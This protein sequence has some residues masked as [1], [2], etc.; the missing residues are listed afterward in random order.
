MRKA[1]ETVRDGPIVRRREW[2]RVFRSAVFSVLVF[3]AVFSAFT[4]VL[5][6][7]SGIGTTAEFV[8]IE[9]PLL[10][11]G[12]V[13]AYCVLRD[14]RAR[15]YIAAL[16]FTVIYVA[17]DLYYWW[18]GNIFR[19][20]DVAELPELVEVLTIGEIAFYSTLLVAPLLAFVASLHPSRS[21]V[22]AMVAALVWAL[23]IAEHQFMPAVVAFV[24]RF[25]SVTEWS[26]QRSARDTG[27][28]ALMIYHEAQ[29]TTATRRLASFHGD[30]QYSALIEGRRTSLGSKGSRRNVHFIVLE[31]FLDPTLLGRVRYSMRPVHP[32]FA[33][34]FEGQE[35]MALS[36][37]F[38]GKSSQAEFEALCGVPAFGYLGSTEFGVL[39][40][41]G[42]KCLP[43]LLRDRGYQTMASNAFKPDFF[44]T[45]DAYRSLG[46]DKIY[47]P[48][49]YA[50]NRETYLVAGDVA[51]E[52]FLFDGELLK[53]NLAHI[54]AHLNRGS[55][56]LF[57]YVLGIYGH[58]PHRLNPKLRPEII[59]VYGAGAAQTKLT[60]YVNQY[61]YRTRAVAE[62]VRDLRALDPNSM[63]V[64]MSDHLPALDV[65]PNGYRELGYTGGGD[66]VFH[67]RLYVLEN[68]EPRRFVG[69][70]H[71]DLPDVVVNYLTGSYHCRSN[72]CTV[73]G[74]P[75]SKESYFSAY[76][77]LLAE[78]LHDPTFEMD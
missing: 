9:L 24:E 46:F 27:R 58:N 29:R 56:P 26:D 65:G 22:A 75:R 74:R 70:R 62:Y 66:T 17:H 76:L 5:G 41:R 59:Q 42:V 15:A 50:P 12:Y 25:G 60:S 1:A 7:L 63:I 21:L 36:S 39:I 52:E 54:R 16:P 8:R 35:G 32:A 61:Y 77:G 19:L 38:G 67:N 55:G 20:A 44:N 30:P 28:F 57:N 43:R 23:P 51:D 71:Y 10:M 13:V 4:K 64:I 18:F 14:T 72:P 69:L 78:E 47:F 33:A 68:G 31:S 37:V 40:G 3:A 2:T 45:L 48:A 53:Q 6:K 34:L 49:E 11:A 73:N